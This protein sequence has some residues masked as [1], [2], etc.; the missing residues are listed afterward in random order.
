M[1]LIFT[2]IDGTIRQFDGSIA[3]STVEA[4]RDLRAKG[5]KVLICSGRPE[6][7]I[8]ENVREIG[9]D[10]VV[11]SSGA[12]ITYEG[13]CIVE[14]TIDDELLQNF[15]RYASAHEY[16]VA[17]QNHESG[18][19]LRRQFASFRMIS[20]ETQK[21]L[22]ET[23][24]RLLL[25]PKPVDTYE[26]LKNIEKFMFFGSVVPTD[27]LT[28]MWKGC[29]DFLPFS[30]PCPVPYGGE[31]YIPGIDKGYAIRELAKALDINLH[32][33]IAIGDSDNDI[34]M[35]KAAGV[36]IAMGNCT[37]KAG[38]AADIITDNIGDNGFANAFKNLGLL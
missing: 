1:Y 31:G 7:E 27:A 4:I 19:I 3:P 25:I 13:R 10:G 20:D 18:Y 26:D 17:C 32:N 22:G 6:S 12:R 24:K 14:H 30:F 29:F 5:N 36:G 9:F 8:E 38:E 15:V 21:R 11:S 28:R 16:V 37:E 2:D 34:S 23:N 33:T 35:L